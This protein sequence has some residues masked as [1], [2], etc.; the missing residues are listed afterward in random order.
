VNVKMTT[1]GQRAGC[2]APKSGAGEAEKKKRGGGKRETT[3]VGFELGKKRDDPFWASTSYRAFS[4][5]TKQKIPG[6]GH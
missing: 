3:N 2:L 5:E 6:T 4:G 1:A